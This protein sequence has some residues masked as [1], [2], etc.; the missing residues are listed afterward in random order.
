M[1]T[2][3]IEVVIDTANATQMRAVQNFFAELNGT[4]RGEIVT[5]TAGEGPHTSV[6][7]EEKPQ[8]G[9]PAPKEEKKK[10][11]RRTKEQIAADKAELE[12][13]KTVEVSD[14]VAT[15]V[16]A[17]EKKIAAGDEEITAG[18]IRLALSN[19]V[20]DHRDT[21]KVKMTELGA[22]NVSQLKAEDY[23]EII[24]FL[25]AL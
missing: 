6:P 23:P 22:A 21:I 1:Q 14:K 15:E 10:R 17:T 11:T 8:T 5:L 16:K 13:K 24:E 4:I 19:K 7:K 9:A 2:V 3:K 18:E 12:A 20:K 25:N